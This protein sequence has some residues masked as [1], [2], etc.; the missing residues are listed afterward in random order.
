MVA[1]LGAP[2]NVTLQ[3]KDW[4]GVRVRGG[5]LGNGVPL[6]PPSTAVVNTTLVAVAVP[7]L[8]IVMSA[9]VLVPLHRSAVDV[10]MRGA[11][12]HAVLQPRVKL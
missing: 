5:V 10:L 4:P 11:P 3:T 12:A 6:T 9:T 7:L 8:L 1:P 2:L